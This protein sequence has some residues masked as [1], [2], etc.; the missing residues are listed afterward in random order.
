MPMKICVMIW[1][2]VWKKY[3]D[4]NDYWQWSILLLIL[5]LLLLV[6]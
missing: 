5:I 3:N 6:M 2:C 4:I 1:Q